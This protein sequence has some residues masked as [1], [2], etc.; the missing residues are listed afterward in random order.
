MSYNRQ[1]KREITVYYSGDV[2]YPASQNGGTRHYS[3]HT[4]ETIYFDVH[5]DTAPFDAAVGHANSHVDMLTGSVV[6]TEAAHVKNIYD[7]STQVGDTI[8]KGFFK[9]VQS[10]ISQQIAEL[11]TRADALLLQ[12]NNLA[13]RCKDKERQM[14]EDYQRLSSRYSDIFTDLNKELDNR[15]HSVD[16]PVFRA[17][18][19]FDEIG[20]KTGSGDLI[21]TISVSAGEHAHLVSMLSANLAKR[22]ARNAIEKGRKFLATQY[23]TNHILESCLRPGGKQETFCT[24]FCMMDAV[25]DPG[26]VSR[27]LHVSPLL[28]GESTDNLANKMDGKRWTA[29]ISERDVN[30]IAGYFR[31][32]VAKLMQDAG[33]EHDRRVAALTAS[34]FDLSGTSSPE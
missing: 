32:D 14:G 31:S 30:A 15:I 3:G 25:S 7:T 8:I 21:S 16:E 18:E 28:E 19:S 33:S 6:A 12:L 10:D 23:R 5:V 26:I 20:S 4:T 27:E 1:F 24:P 11:K 22:Q 9:T 29:G 13:R 34:L 17:A 2:S